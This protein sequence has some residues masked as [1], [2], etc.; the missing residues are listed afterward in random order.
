[1][2]KDGAQAKCVCACVC[3]CVCVCVCLDQKLTKNTGG[4]CEKEKVTTT[5]SS[6]NVQTAI[7]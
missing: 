3:V 6:F 1:M 2:V 5:K 7:L 4:Y